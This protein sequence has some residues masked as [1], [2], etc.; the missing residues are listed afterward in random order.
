MDTLTE[1][2]QSVAGYI[3]GK[4][5]SHTLAVETECESLANIFALDEAQTE[6]LRIAALLHDITKQKTTE[7]Q[8]A[9]CRSFGI[10]YT[11][12]D[13]LSPKVF[14]AR[15]GAAVAKRDFPALAD[16]TVCD[17]IRCHTV[18]KPDMTLLDKLLF[19]A[20]YIEPTRTFEDCVR[21]RALFYDALPD[22][23]P[24]RL[25]HLNRILIT[26]LDMTISDLIGSGAL[27][28]IETMS[29]R[30]ALLSEQ[31]KENPQ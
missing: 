15:T 5:L 19:L 12:Q 2:R 8:I 20:D 10:P 1:L 25:S 9:L 6:K 14:H 4:R 16:Q 17:A 27:I 24:K 11:E 22:T 31:R 7:E 21:L 30:N 13:V 26:A 18:G 3:S 23:A 29:T 28:A